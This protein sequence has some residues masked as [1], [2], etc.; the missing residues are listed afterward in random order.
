MTESVDVNHSLEEGLLH[1]FR[2]AILEARQCWRRGLQLD[3]QS[4]VL[5]DY[6]RSTDMELT[7]QERAREAE[8]LKQARQAAKASGLPWEDDDFEVIAAGPDDDD[9]TSQA[10]GVD[11]VSITGFLVEEEES[12]GVETGSDA[13][14]PRASG[15]GWVEAPE[16]DEDTLAPSPRPVMAGHAPPVEGDSWEPLDWMGEVTPAT[17]IIDSM[18]QDSTVTAPG[19]GRRTVRA[20][21]EPP[22]PPVEQGPGELLE[23]ARQNLASGN[24]EAARQ[25][26]I[27]LIDK[28]RSF[29]GAVETLEEAIST[30]LTRYQEI[31]GSP[32]GIPELTSGAADLFNLKLDEVGGYIYSRIDGVVSLD[33]LYTMSTHLD[34]LHVMRILVELLQAGVIT[35]RR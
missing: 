8:Q 17:G 13:N 18:P 29:P 28:N 2:G 31:L 33:D 9:E 1:F 30:L 10:V 26:L 3:P 16:D 24:A 4:A 32:D 35:L 21:V 15:S 23:Q 25:L 27:V 22:P 34:Q 20:G 19:G 5:Q 12:G 7:S 11:T 6:L 14:A